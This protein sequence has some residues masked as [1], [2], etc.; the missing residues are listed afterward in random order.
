M[1]DQTKS[2]SLQVTLY[3]ICAL[4]LITTAER[5]DQTTALE[6]LGLKGGECLVLRVQCLQG[7][8]LTAGENLVSGGSVSGVGVEH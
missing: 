4:G 5:T 1:K 2:R 8:A 6:N 7:G 3:H